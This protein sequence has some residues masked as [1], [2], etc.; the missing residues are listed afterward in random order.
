MKNFH[1]LFEFMAWTLCL[2]NF[3]STLEKFRVNLNWKGTLEKQFKLNENLPLIE[4]VLFTSV[5]RLI[6]NNE[7]KLALKGEEILI[8]VFFR[9]ELRRKHNI[10]VNLNWKLLIIV[11]RKLIDASR[12]MLPVIKSN[13][14]LESLK[15]VRKKLKVNWRSLSNFFFFLVLFIA[16]WL[17][18][19]RLTHSL[20]ITF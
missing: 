1:N 12:Y 6:K 11:I 9:G 18:S 19:F 4:S 16:S 5:F 7:F 14:T 10:K 17:V 2:T 15:R 3:C 20:E 13:S 8:K